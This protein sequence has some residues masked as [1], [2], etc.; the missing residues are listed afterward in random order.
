MIQIHR[1]VSFCLAAS[2]SNDKCEIIHFTLISVIMVDKSVDMGYSTLIL[3]PKQAMNS[4]PGRSVFTSQASIQ[5]EDL[6]DRLAEVG[7]HLEGEFGGGD[8]LVVFDGVDGLAGD[9]DGVGQFLLRDAE[10]GPFDPDAILH[11]RPPSCICRA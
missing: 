7:G 1:D 8:E 3:R 10:A 2:Y 5:G 9:A 4:R 11:G 6:I